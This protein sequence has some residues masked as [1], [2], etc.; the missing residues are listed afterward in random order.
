MKDKYGYEL[1]IGDDIVV[2]CRA[3]GYD[4]QKY[5]V[6]DKVHSMSADGKYIIYA[7]QGYIPSLSRTYETTN[8]ADKSYCSQHVVKCDTT[9]GFLFLLTRDNAD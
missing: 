3:E 2:Q 7:W 6:R 8:Q 9:E 4:R 5:I 1:K